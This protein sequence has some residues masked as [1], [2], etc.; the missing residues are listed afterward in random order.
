MLLHVESAQD[1][2]LRVFVDTT[3]LGT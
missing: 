3:R 1:T 2:T